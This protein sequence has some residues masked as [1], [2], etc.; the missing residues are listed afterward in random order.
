MKVV[1]V[2]AGIVGC[3]VGHELAARGALVRILDPRGVGQGATRASA[4][5]LAPQIEGHTCQLRR[6]AVAS[7]ALY[8]DFIG[9]VQADSGRTVEY[10][11]HGTTE[12]AFTDA[13]A[14]QLGAE[15]RHLEDAG[16]DHMLLDSAELH[17]R[18]PTLAPGV[19]S[20]LLV[21][22]H[23]YVAATDLTRAV[24]AAA[25]ARG[26]EISTTA[27]LGVDARDGGARVRTSHET[28]ESDA[29]VVASGS[30]PVE[31]RPT[32]LPSVTPIRGQ[33][34]HVKPHAGV[35]SSVIWGPD[36]YL[37]P[38]RDGS[39]LIGATVEDVGFDERS[40]EDGVRG[41]RAAAARVM[42]GLGDAVVREVRVGLRP[43]GEDELPLVGRSPTMP[44]VFLALGHYRNGVLLSP[45]T[46]ALLGGLIMDGEER[47]ELALVRPGR[48]GGE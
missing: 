40:T 3:A 44:R 25:A 14:A 33:L 2:G 45:L 36:C 26:A 18:E 48:T 35:P 22:G 31:V 12:V 23:G 17:R 4:G 43:R 46:A 38:W 20:G 21:P 19:T 24:A 1:V 42:P 39:V 10:G 29:V 30:W 13:Q 27:V 5:I 9:R 16:I 28:I 34:V 32:A 8:D 15:A 11:R 7:L 41:L 37:V 6:L 47:P